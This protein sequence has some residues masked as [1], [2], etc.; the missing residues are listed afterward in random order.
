MA[1]KAE[2]QKS[3]DELAA[4]AL[5][6]KTACTHFVAMQPIVTHT[7]DTPLT[8]DINKQTT[9]D[10]DPLDAFRRHGHRFLGCLL[11]AGEVHAQLAPLQLDFACQQPAISAACR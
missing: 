6:S 8:L 1:A 9:G 2:K 3:S 7:N 11:S 10:D 5:N 4:T